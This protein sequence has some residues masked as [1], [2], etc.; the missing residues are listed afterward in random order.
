MDVFTKHADQSQAQSEKSYTKNPRRR[1]EHMADLADGGDQFDMVPRRLSRAYIDGEFPESKFRLLL[2][3]MSHSANWHI[4]REYLEKRFSNKTLTK[5]LTELEVE[6]YIQAEVLPGKHGGV[7]KLYHVRSIDY[8][9]LYRQPADPSLSL[10]RQNADPSPSTGC[11]PDL[12][13][14]YKDTNA[15]KT[16]SENTHTQGKVEPVDLNQP[17]YDQLAKKMSDEL[18]K[19]HVRTDIKLMALNFSLVREN[20]RWEWERI[21]ATFGEAVA[22]LV[23]RRKYVAMD[24]AYDYYKFCSNYRNPAKGRTPTKSNASTVTTTASKPTTAEELDALLKG[25]Q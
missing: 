4:R 11:A 3:M 23:A 14:G 5:Y 17:K 10:D 16:N 22:Y 15:N 12:G 19:F 8:W 7:I 1:L 2:C 24:P 25:D 9:E 13:K 20:L 6:G 18:A 21:E